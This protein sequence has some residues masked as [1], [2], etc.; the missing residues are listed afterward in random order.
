LQKRYGIIGFP[1]KHS[2]SP[3]M[4]EA[5]FAHL[6]I[7]AS[8][9]LFEISPDK[10]AIGFERLVADGVLGWNVTVP[11]KE[12]VGQYLNEIDIL[13][14]L[15]GSINTIVNRDGHIYGTST[16]GYGLWR[17]VEEVF[18]CSPAKMGGV[19]FV[20]AG[21][22]ARATSVYFALHGVTDIILINRTLARAENLQETIL[23]AR[24]KCCVRS[25]ASDDNDEIRELLR[26]VGLVIQSTSLGLNADDC[27]PLDITCLH[28][29]LAVMDMIYYQTKFLQGASKIGCRVADGRGMLLHQGCRSFEIWTG[30][31]AP[32]EVMRRSLDNTLK[33]R[34]C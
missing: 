10:L 1:V 23:A 9:E 13:S 17:A 21:G 19:A 11:Y 29:G 5:G 34:G 33:N 14:V 7:D 20:G 26:G 27:L 8:Y 24:S 6:G 3:Q 25:V 22:A 15:S 32:V 18:G 4:Q 2:V 30:Q 28:S 16:D 31:K 12:E